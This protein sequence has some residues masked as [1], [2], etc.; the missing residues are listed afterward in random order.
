MSEDW[1]PIETA[2]K[3]GSRQRV[4]HALDPSSQTGRLSPAFGRYVDGRWECNQGFVC[5]DGFLRWHPTHWLPGAG[6]ELP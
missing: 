6:K 3:D 2:P 4:S 1:Q 5:T